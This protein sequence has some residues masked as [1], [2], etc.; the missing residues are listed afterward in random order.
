LLQ[1]RQEAI[2]ERFR[3]PYAAKQQHFPGTNSFA[4]ELSRIKAVAETAA[5]SGSLDHA[6]FVYA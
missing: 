5:G 3:H 2:N 4:D 1:V 6:P